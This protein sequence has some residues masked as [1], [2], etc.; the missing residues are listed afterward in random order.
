[1]QFGSEMLGRSDNA[2][3]SLHDECT[4]LEAPTLVKAQ[5]LMAFWKAHEKDGIVIGRDIPSRAIAGL[6]SS[7]MIYEPMSGDGDF[8]VRHAGTSFQQRFGM[9][10]TGKRMSELFP[11]EDFRDHA[12]GLRGVLKSGRPLVLGSR[13]S[14]GVVEKMHLEIVVLPVF[15]PNRVD[16]WALVGIFYFR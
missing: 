11:P 14:A 2:F 1:V 6:L 9:E 4:V 7:L 15:A 3:T 10:I 12:E 16:K 5:D 8:R 13:V